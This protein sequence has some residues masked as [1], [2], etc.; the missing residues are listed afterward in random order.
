MLSNGKQSLGVPSAFR[1]PAE[2]IGSLDAESCARV[3][4]ASSDVAMIIDRDGVIRD[5]AI[6]A[7][8]MPADS[9]AEF[10][11]RRWI[12]TVT[13]ES[14]PKVA[15][16]LNDARGQRAFRWRE[17]NQQLPQGSIPLRY[18]AVEA[19]QDGKVIA[20]GRDLRAAA[21]LQQK[22]LEA[23]QTMERD[24][25]RLRQAETRYRVLFQM[26]S[27]AV[28]IVD[29]GT[30]KIVEANPAAGSL[31]AMDYHSLAAKPFTKLFHPESRDAVLA[32]LAASGPTIPTEP[33][34]VR[35]HDGRAGFNATASLFRQDRTTHALVSLSA[36]KAEPGAAVPDS[37]MKL[38]RVLDR[39]P[40]AFVVADS[41]LAIV[42]VNVAFLELAQLGSKDAVRGQ[43]L[44][45]F[46][47]RPGVDMRVFVD[48]LRDHGWVRNF[49][50]VAR[51]A[52]GYQEDVEVSAVLIQEGRDVTYGLV[53]RRLRAEVPTPSLPSRELPRTAEQLMQLVGRVSLREIVAETT[54]VIERMCIEAALNLTGNNRASAAEILGLSRQSLYSKMNRQTS[55]TSH[56]DR[57]D[58]D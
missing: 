18:V 50:T 43:P 42:D 27:E 10:V 17:V 48:N 51:T 38:L 52:F 30:K 41:A 3:I 36:A 25:A 46:V 21:K 31:L 49:Q 33:L 1:L 26:A 28:L 20:L 32:L 29:P 53:I 16:M 54:E 22:L 13:S 58:E 11:E 2:T 45:R 56:V 24:Y 55:V 35:L 34:A 37:K 4:A 47:G 12:D 23:Q 5:I 9:F 40:D 19:G 39:M 44:D 57:S 15:E 8:D 6:S 14:R 7:A